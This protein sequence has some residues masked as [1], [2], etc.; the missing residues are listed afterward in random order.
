MY[1]RIAFYFIL[2]FHKGKNVMLEFEKKVNSFISKHKLLQKDDQ[3][4]VAVSG[5]PD[6][7][8]LLHFLAKHQTDA[9]YTISCAHV[10]HMLRGE[11]SYKDLVFVKDFCAKR[12]IPF[13]FASID[14]EKKMFLDKKGMQETSRKYRYQFFEKIMHK[15]GYNKLALGHHGDDQVET[16]LMRLTRGSTGISRAGIQVKRP[17]TVGKMVRPLLSVTKKEIEEYCRY[18]QLQPRIDPS[19]F[20]GDYTRNRF[21]HHVLPFL[22]RENKNIHEHFQRF[23][24]EITDDERFLNKLTV[25]KMENMMCKN[26][27]SVS[28]RTLPFQKLPLPL[29]RRGIQLILNYLYHEKV[30]SFKA[31]HI[32]AIHKLLISKNPSGQLHLPEGLTVQR[33]YQI[34]SFT[35]T[36][37]KDPNPYYFEIEEN[38]VVDLPSGGKFILTKHFL[39]QSASAVSPT[40]NDALVLDPD[41]VKLPLIIRTRQAGDRM[42]V[43]GLNGTKKISRIFIDEKVPASE[44]SIWP[45]V[46]DK[47]GEVLWLPYLKKS[48]LHQYPAQNKTYYILHY[49][50]HR[51]G[52]QQRNEK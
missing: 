1:R 7:L 21:R 47:S 32:E 18:Y 9:S 43:K 40:S 14:I 24:E 52:G 16:I 50:S 30:A 28:L 36:Q 23:S 8:A 34:C 20:K 49:Q 19:N 3:V 29:Q 45:V 46:T 22:K 2:Y 51:L 27:D 48:P 17:F 39:D 10:D 35:F 13:H 4:L 33:S 25:E 31:V 38:E 26:K 42:K 41:T 5:G 44:R 6:S 37:M 12:H 15:F 11:E